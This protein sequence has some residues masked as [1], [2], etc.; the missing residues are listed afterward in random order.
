MDLS[1]F[2]PYTYLICQPLAN[3]SKVQF[4][5]RFRSVCMDGFMLY[6]SPAVTFIYLCSRIMLS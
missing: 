1:Y 3:Y 2:Y 6:T 4:H 5:N